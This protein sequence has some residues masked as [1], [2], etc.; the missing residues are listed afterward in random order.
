MEALWSGFNCGVV[1]VKSV[2]HFSIINEPKITIL[3]ISCNIKIL[4]T[5]PEIKNKIVKLNEVSLFTVFCILGGMILS[6]NKLMMN[7]PLI[8]RF[9]LILFIFLSF[10]SH[11][12][13][14]DGH[15]T[16]NQ[17][18]NF[19]GTNPSEVLV[20]VNREVEDLFGFGRR[21]CEL[22]NIPLSNIVFLDI[23][24]RELIDGQSVEVLQNNEIIYDLTPSDISNHSWRYFKKNIFEP[25]KNHLQNNHINGEPLAS[26]IKYMVIFKGVPYKIAP[27]FEYSYLDDG[28]RTAV[29]VDALLSIA[30][31]K[32]LSGFDILNLFASP[33]AEQPNPYYNIETDY[34]GNHKFRSNYYQNASGIKLSYLVSRIDGVDYRAVSS[35]IERNIL[36]DIS[37][38]NIFVLDYHDSTSYQGKLHAAD[39]SYKAALRLN[40]LGYD[41]I[42]EKTNRR[43][44]RF[45]KKVVGYMSSGKHAGMPIKT[46]YLIRDSGTVFAAG[47]VVSTVESFS[48]FFADSIGA[49]L[50][51]QDKMA[52]VTEYLDAGF[53]GGAG[54]SYEPYTSS[55]VS[56]SIFFP[57]YASGYNLVDAA[58]MAMPFIGFRNV[59]YGDPFMHISL[60]KQTINYESEISDTA[61]FMGEVTVA[62]GTML[63][64]ADNSHLKF[65]HY[66]YL[67][68]K[69]ILHIGENVSISGTNRLR[70]L[71]LDNSDSHPKLLW[72]STT[73]TRPGSTFRIYRKT[74]SENWKLIDSTTSLKYLDNSILISD[75]IK[76][77][78]LVSYRVTGYDGVNESAPT[79]EV[80]LHDGLGDNIFQKVDGFAISNVY[81]NPF[82]SVLKIKYVVPPGTTTDKY[83]LSIFDILGS[84][85]AILPLDQTTSD[86]HE[87]SFSIN[88]L[89]SGVYFVVLTTEKS[90]IAKKVILFR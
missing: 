82:S 23:P 86:I 55:I 66:G 42:Y 39:D 18:S 60:G 9:C 80:I 22:H 77:G 17:N 30:F 89:A 26:Q 84:E 6:N 13:R 38:N 44:Y 3:H 49:A 32:D 41:Y 21:Y 76:N 12:Q 47:S 68:N 79:N 65:K 88:N 35:L 14:T 4:I 85:I 45:N 16:K 56:D 70:S 27:H 7:S 61:L 71:I 19:S 53:S 69:G 67:Q 37:G 36:R 73:D 62:P 72:A 34:S 43:L 5:V 58:Y 83:K 24:K 51:R 87:T 81:P 63:K 25:I 28:G 54:N 8:I 31:Q 64:L 46:P 10:G 74:G 20:I 52:V 75:V 15:L 1:W 90:I 57:A 50:S 78:L 2:F 29:S 59:V 11:A 40:Q 33:H 48:A